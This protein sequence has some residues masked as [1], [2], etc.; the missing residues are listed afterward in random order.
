MSLNDTRLSP[1]LLEAMY[2][3]MLIGESPVPV[4]EKAGNGHEAA[5]LGNHE[6]RITVLVSEEES[7]YLPEESLAFLM[8]IL[9]A[10]KLSMAD[11]ALLNL[12]RDPSV[13]DQFIAEKLAPL[14]VLLFGVDPLS[15]G[16]PLQFPHYQ[17]QSFSN[18]FYLSAPPLDVLRS[19][20]EEKLKLWTSLKKIFLNG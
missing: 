2:K 18:R 14:K 6:K 10:C 19:N 16:M 1:F 4:N 8:D 11:I 3:N 20:K 12:A 9:S 17:V 7:A 13:T 15:I 5:F